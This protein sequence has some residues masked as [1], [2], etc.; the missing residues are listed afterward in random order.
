MLF[1][2]KRN[3]TRWIIIMTSFV[4]VTLIMWNTYTFFQIFKNDER[5]KIE[6]WAESLKTLLNADPLQDD[7]ELP[8][9]VISNNKTIPVILTENNSI[10][11]TTNID[12]NIV[13]DK[14]KLADFLDK[15][16]KQNDPIIIKIGPG[17][18]QYLYYGN[19][20][21]L[22]KLKY[23]PI[24]LLLIIFLFGALVYNFYR[25]TKMATQNKLWAGMA[26]ETAHQI[27]TPLSSLIGWLEI[28]K[29]DNVDETT[30][31]EIEK[32]INRFQTITDR[33]SKIGSEPVLERLNIIEETEQSFDY[34]KSRF[35]KQVEFSFKAPKKPIMVSLNPALHSWT[36]EN[37]V[38]NAIDAMKGKGKISVVI[39]NDNN[40]VKILVT[41]TGSGI[42][43]KQF[44][45]IFEPGFTTKKRGWGLG[46]SLTKRIVEE[47]HKG[48]IKVLHSEIGKGT[49][50]QVSFKKS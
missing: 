9:Q 40:L 3:L 42:P 38:K 41:D 7:V 10:I 2:E 1:S 17:Q 24:A 22:N 49:T 15:L 47:Y 4:I 27:G 21:L 5:V 48:K 19:S 46:L 25:S 39:E 50:M 32:D 8:R 14:T 23:Y 6:V 43:K 18:V 44:N 31:A 20:S 45:S 30:I 13:K 12:E 16:K 33:F 11:N 29:A 37:L 35:S 28:M 26:K 36:V 34:L